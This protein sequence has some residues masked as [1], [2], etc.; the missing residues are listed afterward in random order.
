MK[1]KF[2][3]EKNT[4]ENLGERLLTKFLIFTLIFSITGVC[5]LQAQ[6][7]S[8]S[9]VTDLWPNIETQLDQ[10]KSDTAFHFI[11]QS[12]RK[13]C[14]GDFDCQYETYTSLRN[15]IE[16]IFNLPA[17]IYVSHEI[18]KIARRE[19]DLEGEGHA[20]MNLRRFYGAMKNEELEA[21]NTEKAQRIFEETGNDF[22]VNVLK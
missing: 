20:Y 12:V 3:K 16:E 4:I 13:Q 18:V 22:L 5:L 6:D 11:I 1:T 17:A 19:K 14:E 21:V 7:S 8:S 10:Q 2:I 9:A 15:E